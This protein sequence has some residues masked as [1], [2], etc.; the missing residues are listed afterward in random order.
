M[1]VN[2]HLII[3]MLV[4]SAFLIAYTYQR[5]TA[6]I[7]GETFRFTYIFDISQSMNVTD[8]SAVDEEVTRL[9][10]A[11][12]AAIASL[13][14]L[15]C[16][17]EIGVALFSGHRAFLLITPIEICANYSELSTILNRVDWRMTW[18]RSSEVAKG[19]H[20]SLT[21]LSLLERR[22]RLVFFTD[23]Q[24]SPPLRP[25]I[26]PKFTGTVG[27]ISGMIVGVGGDEPVEIPKFDEAGNRIGVWKK[28]EVVQGYGS[29]K[30]SPTSGIEHL[31][32]LREGYLKEIADK[33]GLDYYR[34]EDV[35]GFTRHLHS[36]TFGFNRYATTDIRWVIALLA[37]SLIIIAS[38]VKPRLSSRG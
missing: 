15:P 20:K 27:E 10:F 4:V 32:F 1:T 26:T 28:D 2:R 25:E 33:T 37:L 7:E 3:G 23:G 19:V 12:R 31:S 6:L 17:S 9:E 21:L 18:E 22:T 35:G 34:L 14:S 8:A 36:S 13:S 24:E 30:A 16:G 11:K 38:L 29:G 5:P